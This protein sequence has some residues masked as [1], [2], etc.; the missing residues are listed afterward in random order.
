MQEIRI[1]LCFTQ[2][3]LGDCRYKNKSKMLRD[4]NG[5]VMLLASWWTALMRYAAE[6][7][8]GHHE[9]V[10]EIDW[11][12]IVEGETS[13]YK[14]FY[15][16]G[17]FT[18]HEAFLPGDRVVVCAVVP[19][20]IPLDDFAEMLRIAGKYRGISPYRKDRQYGTFTVN[21][22]EPVRCKV[23]STKSS[24]PPTTSTTC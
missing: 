16:P 8:N 9:A 5:R 21:T 24:I 17:K 15:G 2:H 4:P 3:C 18:V 13:E 10:K 14:R 1:T 12:P 19:T 6:V 7:F 22:V 11:D 23:E 20:D